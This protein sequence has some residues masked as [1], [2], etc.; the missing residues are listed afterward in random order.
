[1]GDFDPQQ[2]GRDDS[3]TIY[4]DAE[5]PEFVNHLPATPWIVSTISRIDTNLALLAAART[6]STP[7]AV[8]LTAHTEHDRRRLAATDADLVLEPFA[9]A[10]A[11][12]ARTIAGDQGRADNRSPGPEPTA[13]PPD[14]SGGGPSQP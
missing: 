11:Q 14:Q 8:A 7:V 13:A 1:V 5:D 9:A 6:L 4:G 2:L 12:A 10:A 3:A